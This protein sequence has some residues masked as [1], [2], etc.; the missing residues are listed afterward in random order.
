MAIIEAVRNYLQD[1]PL[2][3]SYK[4]IKVEFLPAEV[5]YF[6]IEE[7]PNETTVNKYIDGSETKQFTFVLASRFIY[8]EEAQQTIDNSGFFEQFA[9]WVSEQ[10]EQGNLPVLS[11]NKQASDLEVLTSGYLF[12]IANGM[13]DARYQIQMRLIYDVL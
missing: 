11:G 5:G 12:N 8:S 9:E 1:C 7:V 10:S 4:Q 3:E 6:S 13:R 2:L